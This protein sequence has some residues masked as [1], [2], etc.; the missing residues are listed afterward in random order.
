MGK[1][2]IQQRRGRGTPRYRAKSHKS[3]GSVDYPSVTIYKDTFGGQVV[4]LIHDPTRSA[5]LAKVLLEDFS[6]IFIIAPQNLKVGQWIELGENAKIQEGNILPLEKIPEG[7][8][9][10]NIEL[11]P[12]DG[13]KLVRAGGTFAQVVSHETKLGLTYLL[14]PSKRTISVNSK[15]RASIGR[16]AGAGKKEKPLTKAGLAY[17]KYKAKNK[18]YPIVSGVSMNPVDHPFGGGRHT[19]KPTTT[20]RDTPPGRKVGHI[21]A[22]RTGRKKR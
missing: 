12:G 7:T 20:R 1:R 22:K 9:V 11:K 15:S 8:Q 14:L 19:G 5:P 18:L 6:E 3:K 17:Y 16:V 13:G 2:L 4:E 21:A 10:Y